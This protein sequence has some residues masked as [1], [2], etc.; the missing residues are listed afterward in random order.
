[1]NAVS[2]VNSAWSLNAG[3][4]LKIQPA[5]E[6]WALILRAGYT[7]AGNSNEQGLSAGAGLEFNDIVF[8]YTYNALAIGGLS[9]LAGISYSFAQQ[10]GIAAVKPAD[11]RQPPA[12]AQ[13]ET[14]Y[15]QKDINKIMKDLCRE[16]LTKIDRDRDTLLF[17][18]KAATEDLKD[19]DESRNIVIKL[20]M[21][22]KYD[23]AWTLL[24]YLY[25]GYVYL[26]NEI[27]ARELLQE[28]EARTKRS[29]DAQSYNIEFYRNG[30][31]AY[32]NKDMDTAVASMNRYIEAG[33]QFY[34]EKARRIL[35]AAYLMSGMDSYNAGSTAAAAARWRNGLKNEPLNAELSRCLK[36][37]IEPRCNEYFNAGMVAY[38]Q[39]D[40]RKAESLWK[41]CLE[42]DPT[43]QRAVK[44]LQRLK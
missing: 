20:M 21:D 22:N 30:L 25:R 43:D 37:Y 3:S 5:I 40:M 23:E 6:T 4:A 34:K 27:A 16:T 8:S 28:T 41:A 12:A 33:G 42:I 17:T 18:H 38:A 15:D 26:G 19:L 29:S 36:E 14:Q 24:K 39:G 35:A 44:A 13:V 32:V 2:S 9:H 11:N 10:S 7:R 31:R 1:L